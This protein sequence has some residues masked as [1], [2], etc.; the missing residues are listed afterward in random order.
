MHCPHTA[1]AGDEREPRAHSQCQPLQ[2]KSQGGAVSESAPQT[3][4]RITCIHL[5]S[6]ISPQFQPNEF[7]SNKSHHKV[8]FWERNNEAIKIHAHASGWS[9]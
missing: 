6:I 2:Q 7:L 8:S 1:A 5:H 3:T 9:F 4:V